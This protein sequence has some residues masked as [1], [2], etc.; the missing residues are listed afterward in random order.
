MII[1]DPSLP[2]TRRGTV[3]EEF[4]LSI[5]LAPTVLDLAGVPVH[6]EMQGKSLSPVMR[7][8]GSPWRK[9]FFCE[10]MYTGQNYPLIEGV[11]SK[12]YK[13][14]RYFK[15]KPHRHHIRLLTDSIQGAKPVYE[16]LYDLKN[17][18]RETI[19]LAG[20][21]AHADTL[22]SFRI[23]CQELLVEAKGSEDYPKTYRKN[24][25]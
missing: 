11:R 16:E 20:L 18:P 12:D 10:N 23:R 6:A 9:D 17:D 15:P 7:I 14:I 25:F 5:D 3:V 19:N 1:F 8:D 21:P 4:A 22:E 13:Y 2:A 24:D